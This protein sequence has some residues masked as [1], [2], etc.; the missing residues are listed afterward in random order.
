MNDNYFTFQNDLIVYVD[1]NK[2]IE[3][4]KSKNIEINSINQNYICFK[5]N[6]L[7]DDYLMYNIGLHFHIIQLDSIE[8]WSESPKGSI[9]ENFTYIEILLSKFYGVPIINNKISNKRTIRCINDFQIDH[10]ILDRFG[11]EE[12]LIVYY[13]KNRLK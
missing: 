5:Y 11:L 8:I 6:S 13:K 1:M 4:L 7:F 3:N 2:N 9:D 10:F 12:H